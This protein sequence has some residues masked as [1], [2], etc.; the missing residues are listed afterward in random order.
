MTHE[1]LYTSAQ[2]GLKPGS[3][4]FCTVIATEGLTKVLQDRLESLSGYEHAYALTDRNSHA[5]PVN[6]SHLIVTVANLK[7][8]VLSRVADAGADYSG[9]SNKLAH[10]VVLRQDELTAAGP[11]SAIAT[12]GICRTTFDGVAR[13]LPQGVQI[14]SA[15]RPPAICTA[16][17]NI[18]GDAGWAGFLA[19]QTLKNPTRPV[20][21][22]FAPD[23]DVL[24]LVVEAMSLLP[25][26]R[27]WRTTFSTFFTKLPAGVDC[28]W[29]FVLDGTAAADQA[30]RNLQ[31][32]PIDLTRRSQVPVEGPLVEA[33]RT[34]RQPILAPEVAPPLMPKRS[35]KSVQ[36]SSRS[37]V[38]TTGA[39]SAEEGL[40]PV[41]RGNVRMDLAPAK[42]PMNTDD[43]FAKRNRPSPVVIASAIGGALSAIVLLGLIVAY[44]MPSDPRTVPADLSKN[45]EPTKVAPPPKA[46]ERPQPEIVSKEP[47]IAR[48]S[49][50]PVIL[51]QAEPTPNPT[52]SDP[53]KKH[54]G[55]D[56]IFKD[57]LAKGRVLS[58]PKGTG[59]AAGDDRELCKVFVERPTDCELALLAQVKMKDGSPELELRGNEL[60][61]TDDSQSWTVFGRK[62]DTFRGG[63]VEQRMGQFTLRDQSL[64]FTRA[65]D[66]RDE[67]LSSSLLYAK[68]N[69][70]VG[71][72]EIQSSLF[73]P[74]T[75]KP[76]LLDLKRTKPTF[77]IDNSAEILASAKSLR[78]DMQL[79]LN[80]WTVLKER[81]EA[82]NDRPLKFE[83]PTVMGTIDSRV[84]LEF[85]FHRSQTGDAGFSYRAYVY[86]RF[87]ESKAGFLESKS[88]SQ[89][90][91]QVSKRSDLLDP[92]WKDGFTTRELDRI[93]AITVKH[94]KA[95]KD[96]I[97]SLEKEI[98]T[99][100]NDP[101]E[102]S[103]E[104]DL[105]GESSQE[106]DEG[107]REKTMK[108]LM[109]KKVSEERIVEQGEENFKWI[110]E[111]ESRFEEIEKKLDVRFSIYRE[112]VSSSGNDRTVLAETD[113]PP[114]PRKPVQNRPE[115]S[116]KNV[117][118]SKDDK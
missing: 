25:A 57:V 26:D 38:S 88:S 10:H 81:V 4:G 43:P 66:F 99:A 118:R 9:R 85:S 79:S 36:I 7:L 42:I 68:L 32:P 75:Q 20:T 100:K 115:S 27:Q 105:G 3:Y 117:P 67:H 73:R 17:A 92:Q 13:T 107:R 104:Q 103:A 47:K 35:G 28:Q 11:A 18:C 54:A 23:S 84:D 29:R 61:G 93:K 94:N 65:P 97:K 22:I 55:H 34:G 80:E 76:K 45:P 98:K 71:S 46:I 62:E 48:Q 24:P 64:F 72:D 16:W 114:S 109:D 6:Y 78:Y 74:V 31:A 30:R 90:L 52:V 2:Q 70:K 39:L 33:A 50:Q 44:L 86:P 14:P 15:P 60:E 91:E 89:V 5:N 77:T 63:A 49:A 1:L 53:P 37:N 108:E 56:E 19:E 95:A 82:E 69:M 112:F 111:I 87:M 41:R 110:R 83:I 106:K 8:H 58:L 116:P 113:P 12:P 102:K 21:L 101:K 59:N 40:E 96:R 51:H